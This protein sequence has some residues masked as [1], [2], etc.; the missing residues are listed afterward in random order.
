MSEEFNEAEF[1]KNVKATLQAEDDAEYFD[2]P[3]VAIANEGVE[4]SQVEQEA[5]QRGWSPEGV[6]GKRNLTAEEFLDRQ[7]LY[8]D[9]RS[10]K[11]ETRKL[12]EGMEAALKSVEGARKRAAEEAI[13]KYKAQKAEA[14]EQEDFEAVVELDEKI[15]DVKA[16]A[17]AEAQNPSN[18]AFENWVEQNEWYQEDANMREYADMIGIGY[19]N[20]NPNAPIEKVYAYVAKETLKRFPEYL[21]EEQEEYDD[22]PKPRRT[23]RSPVEGARRG[24]SQAGGQRSR[25]SARELSPEER[26]IMRTVLRSTKMSEQEYLKSYFGE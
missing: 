2:D 3:G 6:E 4:Y 19:S 10:L 9:I 11:K 14:Y 13:E 12:R 17:E 26:G 21:G 16:A 24:R 23:R 15:A 7:P 1:K 25:H 20:K 22:V 8:D 5:I 18:E